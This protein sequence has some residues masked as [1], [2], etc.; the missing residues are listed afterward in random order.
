HRSG[1]RRA[2]RRGGPHPRAARGAAAD[3]VEPDPRPRR[4]GGAAGRAWSAGGRSVY[5]T[6]G[7]VPTGGRN[8][9]EEILLCVEAARS[10]KAE[11]ILVLD[12]RGLC[13]FTD[14][15]VICHGTSSRQ[16]ISISEAVEEQLA[17][18]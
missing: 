3:L 4:R 9:K 8:L 1:R 13:N 11:D 2:A 12:L 17:T 10:K 18:S 14:S 7:S 6:S 16:V 15:F 5:S